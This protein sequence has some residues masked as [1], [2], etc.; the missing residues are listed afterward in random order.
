MNFL[1]FGQ[2][3]ARPVTCFTRLIIQVNENVS[4]LLMYK[5]VINQSTHCPNQCVITQ[6]ISQHLNLLDYMR[7]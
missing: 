6:P 2:K 3:M 1:K 7:M 4:Q 5:G